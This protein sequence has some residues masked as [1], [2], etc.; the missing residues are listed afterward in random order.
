MP[1]LGPY[2]GKL[3]N[4]GEVIEL[5]RPG[6][7]GLGGVPAIL[8]ERVEY[9]DGAPW[10][11][12]A[13][14]TGASLQRRV[15]PS[16]GDD[17][18][19]WFAADPAVAGPRPGL[20]APAIAVQP[21]DQVGLLREQ[22][23]LRVQATGSAPLRYQWEHEGKQLPGETN[24]DLV[25]KSLQFEQAGLYRVTVYNAAGAVLSSNAVLSV[26]LPAFVITPPQ[27]FRVRGST[28]L[29]DYG[30]TT[31]HSA[32]FG[33]VAAGSGPLRYQWRFNGS[34]LP[35]ET[36]SSLLV[37]NVDLSKDGFYDV[38]IT[39]DVGTISSPPARL[40]VLLSP[41]LVTV[42]L[43]LSVVSNGTFTAS[44][45]IR[46]NPPPFY[47][48]WIEASLTRSLVGSAE[49]TNYFTSGLIA[50]LNARIWRVVVT[51]DANTVA[52]A[53]TSFFVTG[54]A[55]SD[56]D[57]M[58]DEWESAFGLNPLDGTDAGRD[59]D[60]DGF[61]NLQEYRAGTVPT[62]EG[63]FLRVELGLQ[64]TGTTLTF[65]AAP[66]LTYTLEYRDSLEPGGW[67]KLADVQETAVSHR[68]TVVDPESRPQRYYR[69]VTPRRP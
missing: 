58:P 34:E 25:F 38:R 13:D 1:I 65:D 67:V 17:P 51:N 16:F 3:G 27:T 7:P 42:P 60:G 61:T 20:S 19:A 53:I 5:L 43:S 57:G 68:E 2:S 63:S 48:R 62:D 14:G 10:P 33:V 11:A 41:V 56:G 69:L 35:G 18:A 8:V 64:G 55:D 24:T 21:A 52:T 50:N 12:G 40:S 23:T 39:D 9:R 32:S 4:A 49:T 26:A 31:N 59:P 36:S 47:Y 29:A 15:P 22:V 44:V 37:P 54:L 28:N 45:V 6:V 46:G 66:L 30:S